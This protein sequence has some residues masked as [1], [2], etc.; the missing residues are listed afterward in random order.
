MP[1]KT[2][3]TGKRINTDWFDEDINNKER[4]ITENQKQA[5]KRHEDEF[6]EE[7]LHDNIRDDYESK[8]HYDISKEKLPDKKFDSLKKRT[9]TLLGSDRPNIKKINELK[10]EVSKL[11]YSTG[12]DRLSAILKDI[13]DFLWEFR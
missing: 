8:K 1:W 5:T 3:K 12:D 7:M 11:K 13:K 2:T 6:D 10:E 9:S 4:Q